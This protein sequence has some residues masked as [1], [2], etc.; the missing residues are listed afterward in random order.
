[1][2]CLSD[3]HTLA[4]QHIP[5]PGCDALGTISV[6][7]VGCTHSRG[8][9]DFSQ[10]EIHPRVARLQVPVVRLSVLQLNQHR[11]VLRLP[12]EGKRKH[13]GRAS[14]LP[15]SLSLSL[16]LPLSLPQSVTLCTYFAIYLTIQYIIS[17]SLRVS[18]DI[19]P[20]FSSFHHRTHTVLC[21]KDVLLLAARRC[22]GGH[23]SRV[24]C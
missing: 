10:L 24:A 16:S 1:M 8:K 2:L 12:Q 21:H 11:S 14:P 13:G 3:P 5:P 23:E 22:V 15:L 7:A 18:G 20:F 19:F 9:S 17:T 4:T 6:Q